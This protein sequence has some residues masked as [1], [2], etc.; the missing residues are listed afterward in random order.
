[1]DS[2][3]LL[4]NLPG[5]NVGVTLKRSEASVPRHGGRLRNGEAGLQEPGRGFV[6]QVMEADVDQKLR[7]WLLSVLR[8]LLQILRLGPIHAAPEGVRD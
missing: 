6:P 7:V 4:R 8:A 2:P 3:E 5:F 1:M